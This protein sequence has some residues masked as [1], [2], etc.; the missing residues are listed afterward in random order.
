MNETEWI[1]Y[2]R[3]D[4]LGLLH[5]TTKIKADTMDADEQSLDWDK[6][7]IEHDGVLFLMLFRI[8]CK[9]GQRDFTQG[10]TNCLIQQ[11]KGR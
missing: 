3:A 5:L 2:L 4:K 7:N 11:I 8:C 6:L 10:T 9:V 1:H